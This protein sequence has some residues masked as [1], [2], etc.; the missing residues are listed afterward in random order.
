MC[1]KKRE[2]SRAVVWRQQFK[3]YMKSMNCYNTVL[4]SKSFFKQFLQL[5][6]CW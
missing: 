5:R 3:K 4:L 6:R 1:K 2:V